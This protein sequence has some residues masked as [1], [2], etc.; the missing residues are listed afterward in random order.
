[1]TSAILTIGDELLIGQVINTNQAYIAR[2]LNQA[3]IG[4]SVMLTVGDSMQEILDAFREAWGRFD[5]VVVTGGLGP[6]HDDIT[7]KA[8]CTFFDSPL[9][10]R[11]DLR[12]HIE[13]LPAARQAPWKQSH[14]EQ[15][16]FPAKAVVI[17]NPL[18]TAAGM[19]F[20]REGR[21][22]IVLPGVPYEMKEM[23]DATVAPYRCHFGERRP[24]GISPQ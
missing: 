3:G 17:P 5:V 16:L 22:F 9:E 7:K 12:R 21:H 4:V 14:E 24:T 10:S 8:V 19:H 23:M 18:G 2:K 1:M 11:E 20:E 6:T 13:Q 15:T